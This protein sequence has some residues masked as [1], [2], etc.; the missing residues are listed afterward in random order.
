MLVW[1]GSVPGV[2]RNPLDDAADALRALGERV[3]QTVG[4][5]FADQLR[6]PRPES[7]KEPAKANPPAGT[8]AY[9]APEQGAGMPSAEVADWYAVGVMLFEALT[10]RRP[11]R[12]RTSDVLARKAAV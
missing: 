12:G 6:V 3:R 4:D 5:D 1:A 10:G 2:S 9:M 7:P 8:P 11:F